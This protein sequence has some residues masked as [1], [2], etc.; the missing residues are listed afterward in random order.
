M[1]IVKFFMEKVQAANTRVSSG[2]QETG[3]KRPALTDAESHPEA[4]RQRIDTATTTY[5]PSTQPSNEYMLEIL[6]QLEKAREDRKTALEK[7]EEEKEWFSELQLERAQQ[8]IGFQKEIYELKQEL[9]EIAQRVA[10][11]LGLELRHKEEKKELMKKVER[12]V[13]E[14]ERLN[15]EVIHLRE[16]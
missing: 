14:Q 11:H 4:K 2:E 3:G 9:Q 16:E 15:N 8:M 5:D 1:E 6:Q 12:E 13:Q 10:T 7:L